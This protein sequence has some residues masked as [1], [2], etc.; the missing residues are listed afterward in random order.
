MSQV[1]QCWLHTS[2]VTAVPGVAVDDNMQ[3]AHLAR[4]PSAIRPWERSSL[5]HDIPGQDVLPPDVPTWL[6]IAC[7]QKQKLVSHLSVCSSGG[8]T[9]FCSSES[10]QQHIILLMLLSKPWPNVAPQKGDEVI[11]LR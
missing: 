7:H 3:E 5:R 2:G 11:A 6:V 9:I 8:Q 4:R 1:Q 10:P